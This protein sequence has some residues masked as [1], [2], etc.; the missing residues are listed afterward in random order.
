MSPS[1]V[2]D[3]KETA[4]FHRSIAILEAYGWAG[5]MPGDSEVHMEAMPDGIWEGLVNGYDGWVEDWERRSGRH[6]EMAMG[7]GNVEDSKNVDLGA[8]TKHS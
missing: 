6:A 1:I 4:Q 8:L 2:A 3:H 7:A 5:K